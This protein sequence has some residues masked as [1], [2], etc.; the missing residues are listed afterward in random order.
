MRISRGV[1]TVTAV[2][3]AGVLGGL[4]AS[5]ASASVAPVSAGPPAPTHA[6]Q[7]DFDAFFPSTTQIHVGDSV[8]WKV[9]GF[10]TIT[11]LP[12]GQTPP[13]LFIPAMGNPISGQLDAAGAA[14]WF[15]GQP[16]LVINPAA[17]F[18]TGGNTYSGSGVL[19][20]GVPASPSGPPPPFVVKFT[21]AGTFKFFCLVHPGMTGV[22]KV[23][24][25]SKPV[26]TAAQ[27]R[28]AAKAQEN[29]L[30]RQ[31]R[32]LAKVK[33][34]TATVLAGNDGK[35]AVAWLRFFP[36]NLHIKAG[37]TVNFKVSS[38]R[39]VHTITIGPSA[40]TTGIEHSFTTVHPNPA[41]P[42]T[43]LINPLGAYPSD[44]PPLPAY[45]GSNHGNGFEGAGVLGVG[46]PN[47]S[48]AKITFAKPGIYHYE[49]VIH[50]GMD[51]TITVT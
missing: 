3:W 27:D 2:A 29:A 30:I 17:G 5:S 46:G 4:S 35:G 16:N 39:E 7:L 19:N 21:K 1:L 25:K 13:P 37:T 31:A 32:N 18:P 8:S 45:T 15:N 10:H 38:K 20:S 12:S 42:P 23:L 11:F 43:I 36:Q 6:K 14:F 9:N 22:V 44:P 40:Y 26:P 49:C 33:P 41:G 34:P 48:S 47:P 51:G 24:P 28:A 50:A